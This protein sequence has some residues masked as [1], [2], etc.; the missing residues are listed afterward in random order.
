MTGAAVFSA[1]VIAF[2]VLP[3][4]VWGGA[5]AD[6]RVKRKPPAAMRAMPMTTI[7]IRAT[8]V[9]VF[10]LPADRTMASAKAPESAS[11]SCSSF[12]NARKIVL[13]GQHRPFQPASG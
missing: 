9:L 11:V 1:V 4:F 2:P 5:V 7:T 13:T 10:R 12:F 3:R 8:T 6:F